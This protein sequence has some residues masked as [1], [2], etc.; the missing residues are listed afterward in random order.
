MSPTLS[1]GAA[2]SSSV[3]VDEHAGELDAGGA[4]PRPISRG[5][6]GAQRRGEPGQK[7]MPERPG[8]ELDGALRRPRGA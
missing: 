2:T 7:I 5:L 3:R 4:A 6:V 8:A 1:A